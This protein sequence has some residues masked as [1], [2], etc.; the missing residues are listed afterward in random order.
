M[1]PLLSARQVRKAYGSFVALNNIDFD[2]ARGERHALIGPNGA[3]KSTFIACIA[4]QLPGVEGSIRFKGDE[5]ARLLPAEV[6]K[7]GIGRTFQI[8]RAF[9]QMSALENMT[10]AFII[11]SGRWASLSRAL[12]AEAEDR[13]GGMLA[14][15]GLAARAGSRVADL[16]L[17]DRKRL[18]FGMVLAGDPDLLLLDE[19]TAGMSIKER[20][21]LME[22]V[23]TRAEEAGK[24]LLFVEH[25]IDVVLKIAQRVTVMVRGAVLAAGTP[26]EIAANAQVQA[27]Y[28]GGHH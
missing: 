7:R 27:V 1:S 3:G 16:S 10:A 9:L 11:A 28:L 21:H 22:L 5:V 15:V 2:L 25:D 6:A 17:G 24:T 18:E 20:H 14:T 23:A 13:A 26:V 4:G 19:P 12:L 8:S